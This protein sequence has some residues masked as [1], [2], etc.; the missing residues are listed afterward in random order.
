MH[1]RRLGA[2]ALLVGF[3]S[4][5]FL[6]NRPA[7]TEITGHVYRGLNDHFGPFDPVN[8]AVVSNDWDSTTTTTD[9]VGY[10]NLPLTK[11]IAGDEFVV[12]TVRSGDIVFRQPMVG[13]PHRQDVQIVLPATRRVQ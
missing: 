9:A 10:F 6:L 4:V 2:V 13:A 1:V 3:V 7:T 11:R 8:G 5:I 12:V